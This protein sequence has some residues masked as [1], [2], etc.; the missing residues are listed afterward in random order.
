MTDDA[1]LGEA[2]LSEAALIEAV[3]RHAAAADVP[4]VT[5]EEERAK[6]NAVL[7]GLA[8]ARALSM[9][10]PA[11]LGGGGMP[12]LSAARVVGEAAAV[13]GSAGLIA[14][15]H[16][17]QATTVAR[18]GEGPA[19][20]AFQR[21]LAA[22]QILI[23]SATSEVGVGGDILRSDCRTE[24]DGAGGFRLVK[25]CTN[26]SYLDQAG[27][28]LATAMHEA[29]GR[30]S[31]RLILLEVARCGLV[32]E[33]ETLLL[34]MRGIVNR[35]VAIDARFEAAAIFPAPFALIARTMSAAS[36]VLWA[37][38]W[39]GIAAAAL[40]RAEAAVTEGAAAA[41][42]GAPA[43]R[44]GAAAERLYA[45]HALIRDACAAFDAAGTEAFQAGARFNGLKIQCAEMLGAIVADCAAAAGL[46]GYVEGTRLSLSEMVRDSF[47]A[48]I[49]VSSDRLAGANARVRRFVRE[50]I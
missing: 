25:R 7:R 20:E 46:R 28:I 34:G 15:M 23:A 14:A 39:S 1:A 36:H 19:L 35:A 43:D 41:G 11:G 10:V 8:A 18:H 13:S 24:P 49:M 42:A 21:R 48:R 47:S 33:R 30:A 4:A 27:A 9:P 32:T 16:L 31:Q 2:T 45:M 50:R 22:E 26:I 38:A 3:G 40:A 37:A 12:I 5:P 6:A 17:A 44:L 29:R